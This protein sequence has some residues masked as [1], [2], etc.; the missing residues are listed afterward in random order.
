MNA[1]PA[2]YVLSAALL[3]ITCSPPYGP[4]DVPRR[5][6][7]VAAADVPAQEPEPSCVRHWP[8]ARYRNYQYDHVVHL[9]S[10]CHRPASCRVSTDVNPT[11]VV[12]AI[13][14]NEHL[15]VVT[16]RGSQS[17]EF[18]PNVRCARGMR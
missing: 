3:T 5:I 7:P 12:V 16:S 4:P 2:E 9:E 15:E 11:V 18:T 1:P 8:E 14:P 17:P 6:P 13:A 10:R